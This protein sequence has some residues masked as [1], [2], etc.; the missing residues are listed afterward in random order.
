MLRKAP[1]LIIGT[2]AGIIAARRV[3][4]RRSKDA[5]DD[6][7]EEEQNGPETAAEHAKAAIEHSRQA[8]KKTRESP[9]QITD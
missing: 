5:E 4:G 1:L 2:V 7:Q 3:R 8:V 9:P 6:P